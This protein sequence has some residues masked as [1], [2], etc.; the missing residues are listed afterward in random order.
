MR[1]DLSLMRS[2]GVAILFKFSF[3]V[4]CSSGSVSGVDSATPWTQTASLERELHS[5]DSWSF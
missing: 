3:L 5:A 2:F 4:S 1:A